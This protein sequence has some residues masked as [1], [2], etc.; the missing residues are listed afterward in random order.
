MTLILILISWVIISA[1][2]ISMVAL[3]G[4]HD[5]VLDRARKAVKDMDEVL[6]KIN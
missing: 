1:L 2:F 4:K 3:G 6:K 5:D